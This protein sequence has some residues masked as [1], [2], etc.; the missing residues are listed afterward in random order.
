MLSES[1]LHLELMKIKIKR[2]T[3][4]YDRPP[5]MFGE[6]TLQDRHALFKKI[7][8]EF[9]TEDESS[10]EESTP[11]TQLVPQ[12]K[13]TLASMKSGHPNGTEAPKQKST[14]SSP[15][16]VEISLREDRPALI[17]SRLVW[18]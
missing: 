4:L 6:I 18:A 15:G 17:I 2:A 3:V 13:R 5:K 11:F 16:D 1:P 8:P 10:G 7:M 9:F 12:T 14:N